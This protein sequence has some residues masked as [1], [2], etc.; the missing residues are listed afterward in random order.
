MRLFKVSGMLH[1]EQLQFYVNEW[2]LLKETERYY[3]IK[4]EDGC[5]KRIYREKLN[6]L[7]EETKKYVDGVISC[8]VFCALQHIDDMKH[9]IMVR[10][11]AK[12]DDYMNDLLLNQKAL[13]DYKLVVANG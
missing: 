8:H 3:E 7:H 13:E 5:V 10:L 4:S 6:T 12:I 9:M 1:K 11:N 2:R